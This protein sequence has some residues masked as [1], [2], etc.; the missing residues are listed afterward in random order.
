VHKDELMSFFLTELLPLLL[1][2]I[3]FIHLASVFCG[4]E[5]LFSDFTLLAIF[6]SLVVSN[7]NKN[8]PNVN[9]NIEMPVSNTGE[10]VKGIRIIVHKTNEFSLEAAASQQP[11]VSNAGDRAYSAVSSLNNEVLSYYHHF[12]YQWRYMESQ[13]SNI[14]RKLESLATNLTQE[15][16][17]DPI[18]H[19]LAG[20][21][22]SPDSVNYILGMIIK[23]YPYLVH[24]LT[25][26][27]ILVMGVVLIPHIIRFISNR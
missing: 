17:V 27:F 12:K 8:I 26:G 4:F 20:N 6:P 18:Y 9:I 21:N 7:Y 14:Q 13:V 16:P 23:D 11:A 2:F 22:T 5:G 10:Y 25:F 3:I 15:A 19:G 1:A 24:Y